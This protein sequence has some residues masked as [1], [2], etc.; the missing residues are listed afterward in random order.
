MTRFP[1]KF[2]KK[3]EAATTAAVPFHW[4]TLWLTC[5]HEMCIAQKEVIVLLLH[6]ISHSLN[7]SWLTLTQVAKSNIHTYNDGS[8]HRQIQPPPAS[9]SCDSSQSQ[10]FFFL[11][12]I[13]C[14]LL[15][16]WTWIATFM[17]LL[18]IIDTTLFISLA[19]IRPQDIHWTL[20][21]RSNPPLELTD[22]IVKCK[23]KP[24]T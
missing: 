10:F 18:G 7:V 6:V 11:F 14:P 3:K 1:L 22:M 16:R 17:F 2:M 24:K 20:A 4:C 9:S 19:Y 21:L 5:M 13:Q 8:A 12:I 15:C 23:T